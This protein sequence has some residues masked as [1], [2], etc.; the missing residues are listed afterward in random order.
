MPSLSSLTIAL[1]V[2][3]LPIAVAYLIILC[4]IQG[5]G[6][7]FYTTTYLVF[8]GKSP[9][10]HPAEV[11]LRGSIVLAS[12]FSFIITTYSFWYRLTK[13]HLRPNTLT[14]K[15]A[16]VASEAL[17]LIVWVIAIVARVY[18]L[19]FSGFTILPD[20]NMDW[21]DQRLKRARN[22]MIIVEG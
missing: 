6:S 8:G 11:R 7:S 12:I 10:C 3:Q 18:S 17:V 22:I 21:I 19:G 1:R 15:T 16:H 13:R 14:Q 5:R 9:D 4:Y 20:S 2:V